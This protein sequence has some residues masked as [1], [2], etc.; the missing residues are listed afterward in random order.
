MRSSLRK[1][2][3]FRLVLGKLTGVMVLRGIRSEKVVE[4]PKISLTKDILHYTLAYF[5]HSF[6]SHLPYSNT[7]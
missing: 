2:R 3:F 7:D 6:A 1:S 4:R 5:D